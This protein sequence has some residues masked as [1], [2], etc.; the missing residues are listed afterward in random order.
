MRLVEDCKAMSSKDGRIVVITDGSLVIGMAVDGVEV[1]VTPASVHTAAK[2]AN[3]DYDLYSG[4]SD[5][6]ILLEAMGAEI[7][8]EDCPYRQ[9]CDIWQEYGAE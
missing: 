7:G 6:H 3:A 2:E 5:D 9:V 4:W 8:C 1:D